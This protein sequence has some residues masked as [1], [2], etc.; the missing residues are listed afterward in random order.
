MHFGGPDEALTFQLRPQF[1]G[2]LQAHA[3]VGENRVA[4]ADNDRGPVHL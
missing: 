4:D 3:I 2:D 1:P